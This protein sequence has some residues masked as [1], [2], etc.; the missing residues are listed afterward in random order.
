[1]TQPRVILVFVECLRRDHLRSYG[2]ARETAP[3]ASA[4]VASSQGVMWADCQSLAGDTSGTFR[5]LAPYAKAISAKRI[6][7]F[8]YS[9]NLPPIATHAASVNA[10]HEVREWPASYLRPPK[11]RPAAESLVDAFIARA[12]KMGR[13]FAVLHFQET[14]APYQAHEHVAEFYCDDT[15]LADLKRW[16]PLGE[17][18]LVDLDKIEGLL[19]I[20]P[21]LS[22]GTHSQ[23]TKVAWQRAGSRKR[24]L[25][26]AADP[27]Y[28]IAHYD[29]AIHYVDSQVARLLVAFP[30]ADVWVTG[31][32]GEG[33]FDTGTHFACHA[34]GLFPELLR[35]PL[36]VRTPA[37]PIALFNR[38]V[39]LPATHAHLYNTILAGYGL[40]SQGPHLPWPDASPEVKKRLEGLGYVGR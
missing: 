2:Y 37:R 40:A 16:S 6:Q 35:V 5:R 11:A 25:L 13:F 19:P 1:M 15:Y 7:T 29:G 3:V 33:F 30:D 23:P 21:T 10:Y 26:V 14:H 20:D 18:A 22:F 27:A 12:G 36:I 4:I 17:R 8:L 38:V 31:D 39:S 32:H 24:G 28:Y 34:Y 9:A